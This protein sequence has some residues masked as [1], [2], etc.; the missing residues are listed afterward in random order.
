MHDEA[1]SLI[2]VRRID[3]PDAA[4]LSPSEAFF[5]R[6]NLK[7]RLMNARLGLLARQM[8]ASRNDLA[9]T[10]EQI[11]KYFDTSSR[12]VQTASMQL[13]QLQQSMR[14]VDVPRANDT[15]AALATAAAGR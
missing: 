15:L 10:G 7:I 4:L 2:R 3:H 9:A 6:E 12:R 13:Q 1:R 14:D 8:Q 5:L 11:H